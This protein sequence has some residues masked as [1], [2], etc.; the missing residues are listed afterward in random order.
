MQSCDAR[1][2]GPLLS[3]IYNLLQH[4]EVLPVN[5][6]PTQHLLYPAIF[7][8]FPHGFFLRIPLRS[9]HFHIVLYN[10]YNQGSNF[11]QQQGSLLS[12]LPC[13]EAQLPCK[14]TQ[15]PCKETQLLCK[16]TQL[17][18]KLCCSICSGL[19]TSIPTEFL[20]ASNASRNGGYSP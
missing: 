16:E 15:L 9:L 1:C 5:S 10:S 11:H 8:H 20:N 14:E 17:L 13:K 2:N 6:A 4:K 18:C 19:Q 7:L 12:S 3:K